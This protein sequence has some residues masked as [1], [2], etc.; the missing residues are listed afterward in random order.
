MNEIDEINEINEMDQINQI[1]GY[2]FC[3]MEGGGILRNNSD[4][5]KFLKTYLTN[6]TTSP[7]ILTTVLAGLT[8][9]TV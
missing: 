1:F 2:S 6:L 8:F 7:I 5:E 9:R 4:G 3:I